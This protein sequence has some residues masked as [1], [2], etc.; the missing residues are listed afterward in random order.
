MLQITQPSQIVLSRFVSESNL[1]F[2]SMLILTYC[3]LGLSKI[4]IHMSLDAQFD[5][6]ETPHMG[7]T[8]TV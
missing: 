5:S 2:V 8:R 1:N 6:V 4:F 3:P 7:F